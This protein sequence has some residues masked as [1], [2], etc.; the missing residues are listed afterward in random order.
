MRIEVKDRRRARKLDAC[1]MRTDR[2]V[3]GR[4][5]LTGLPE[6]SLSHLTPLL[7]PTRETGG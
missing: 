5:A 1:E 2:Y 6:H 4:C 3:S 7:R